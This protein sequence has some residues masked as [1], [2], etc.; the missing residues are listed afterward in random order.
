MS[1]PTT[2]T[3]PYSGLT[4]EQALTTMRQLLAGGERNPFLLGQLHNYVADSQLLEGT[5]YKSAVDFFRDN[6][7]GISRETL[8]RAGAVAREFSSEVI[9]RFGVMRLEQLLEYKKAARITLNAD[10]P[11]STFIVVPQEN[12]DLKPKRF[13]GCSTKELRKAL[14]HARSPHTYLPISEADRARYER[15]REAILSRFPKHTRVLMRNEGGKTLMDFE[16]I[17]LD[18]AQEFLQVLREVSRNLAVESE[19]EEPPRSH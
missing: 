1:T 7:P 17:P 8:L 14:E 3:N 19:D 2:P 6:I 11:G 16:M 10:E 5:P 15:I 18:Q 12:G 9:S 4:Q 13:A